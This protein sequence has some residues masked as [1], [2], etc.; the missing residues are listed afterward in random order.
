MFRTCINREIGHVHEEVLDFGFNL[1]EVLF[2][3]NEEDTFTAI[4]PILSIGEEGITRANLSTI[5][6][7]YTNLSIP[8]GKIVPMIVERVNVKASS[9]ANARSSLGTFNVSTNY[10]SRPVKPSD[11]VD[12]SNSAN[13]TWEFWRATAYWR[14][15][16]AKFSGD[17]HVAADS[18]LN[19]QYTDIRGRLD[20]RDER[21]VARPKM[22]MVE[23]SDEDPY[24]IYND[25]AMKLKEKMYPEFNV[26]VDVANLRK[27][28]YNDYGLYDKVYIKLPGSQ[29]LVTARV[30]STSKDANDVARNTIELSNY[31]FSS[32]IRNIQCETYIDA[33]NTSF[34]YPSSRKLSARLVNL[35]YDSNNP[36]SVQY[37]A[38]QMIT[39]TVY[40][41]ENGSIVASYNKLTNAQGYATINMKYNPG[42][43]EIEI[44]FGGDEEYLDCSTSVEANV[45]GTVVVE[46]P[47]VVK[48]KSKT[49]KKS[50]SNKK[51]AKAQYETVS[52]KRYYDKYG[53]SPDGK[54]LMAVGRPSASGELAKYGYSFYKTVFVR[55]CPMCGSKEIFW[56]IFWAGNEHGSWGKFPATGRRESGS[57]EGQIFC[58]KCDADWSIFGKNHN[59]S[60]KDLK[61]YKKPIQ[62]TKSEAYTLK[63]GKM[64]YD[65]VTKTVRKKNNTSS[66]ERV[67]LANDIPA[68]VRKQALS[69]VG[70]STGL[71]AAKK[72]AAWCGHKRN[73][74]WIDYRN[75]KHGI[76]W[77][78]RNK[79]SNC[80]DGT[81]YMLTLMDAAGCTE[82]LRLQ[83]VNVS[84]GRKGHVFAKITV[85]ET[86]SW[87]YV[88]PTCKFENGRKPWNSYI[89]GYGSPPGH[90]YNYNGPSNPPF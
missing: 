40:N 79:K 66:K 56:S 90:V 30:S 28:R 23:T 86:G 8:K 25:A 61:V 31:S 46:K 3:T 62:S 1:E 60:H 82:K 73:L 71:A 77:V 59:T 89:K 42:D 84:S 36:D 65:T 16:F 37:P 27:G 7:N 81:R 44:G 33:Y 43:Y 85:K 14:A 5:I 22:G 10:Y 76:S 4:S 6:G 75:F 69:I 72:I 49:V 39:F 24:A 47:V 21:G 74:K 68:A 17:L 34:K 70:N 9:L 12:T 63:K 15:P 11:N 29:E 58:K 55:K 50:G 53:V 51:N 48:S 38:N 78:H 80:C 19:T 67:A 88:D 64:Y 32:A 26:S 35:D 83:Y 13:S 87:A 2:E 41:K 20:S 18:V 57:A 52:T 54:Y 45:Y